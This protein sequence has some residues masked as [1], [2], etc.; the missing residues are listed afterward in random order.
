MELLRREL[1]RR[2]YG[3]FLRLTGGAA[4][5]PTRFSDFLARETQAFLEADSGDAYDILILQTPPQHGK[6]MSVT[7]ALPAWVLMRNPDARIIL[8][9]YNEESAERFARRNREINGNPWMNAIAEELSD[10]ARRYPVLEKSVYSSMKIPEI[11]DAASGGRAVVLTGVV[12]ECCVL[13]TCMEAIDLG[14]HVIYLRDACAGD[15][16][17]TETAVETILSR[18]PLHITLCDTADYIDSP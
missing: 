6:S 3:W 1:A 7:E 5:I 8:A 12:S 9:S 11:R 14:A 4:W 18:L 16:A 17:E 10:F 15:C 2:N 13:S